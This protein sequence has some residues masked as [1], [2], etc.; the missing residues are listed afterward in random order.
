M[1]KGGGGLHCPPYVSYSTQQRKVKQFVFQK[2]I[3]SKKFISHFL[4]TLL[5]LFICF[6]HVVV[7]KIQEEKVIK[8]GE[9]KGKMR[10]RKGK[11]RAS[12]HIQK[13][14]REPTTSSVNMSVCWSA[15]QHFS[16]CEDA[17][18]C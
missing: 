2:S 7:R 5:F 1:V 17:N 12:L 11:R 13:F 15:G 10:L 3:H 16:L 4:D 8:R 6:L 18:H 9:K 14:S